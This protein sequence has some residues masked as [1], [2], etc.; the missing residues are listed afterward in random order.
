M[1]AFFGAL[2]ACLQLADE[3]GGT[4]RV[5]EAFCGGTRFSEF[6]GN[7]SGLGDTP[8]GAKR[9]G[10][11]R[12]RRG[13]DSFAGQRVGAKDFFFGV[14]TGGVGAGA[15]DDLSR[16]RERVSA[17]HGTEPGGYDAGRGTGTDGGER[18]AGGSGGAGE[19]GGRTDS[20]GTGAVSEVGGV[21]GGIRSGG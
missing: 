19:G 9:R 16:T 8:T 2:C 14:G 1:R 11:R 17:S 4:A 12:R 13:I 5:S 7:R 18:D 6:C 21:S 10:R 20:T 3:S 15:A